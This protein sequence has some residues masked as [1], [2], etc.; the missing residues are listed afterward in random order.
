MEA[1]KDDS[2]SQN[3]L[4]IVCYSCIAEVYNY[5]VFLSSEGKYFCNSV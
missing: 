5:T 1:L 2:C 3:F 4:L